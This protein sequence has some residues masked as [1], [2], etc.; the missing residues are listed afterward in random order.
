MCDPLTLAAIS[1]A[2]GVASSVGQYE[3][4]KD[5]RHSTVLAANEQYAQTYNAVEAE[6]GQ[7]NVQQSEADVTNAATAAQRFGRIAA[8]ASSIGLGA[9]T[10]GSLETAAGVTSA[11]EK[12]ITDINATF[13][14][15]QEG[16]ELEGANLRRTST[17][18][19]VP[20]PNGLTLLTSLGGSLLQGASS[21]YAAGGKTLGSDISNAFS[22]AVGA[23][24]PFS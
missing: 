24:N 14:R 11:R 4:Q 7:T 13:Q 10:G 6:A 2:V 20:A 1:T 17:I 18:N 23:A 15:Q 12:A 5:L 19:S 3:G 9:T 21:Y 8:S 22:S 16:N